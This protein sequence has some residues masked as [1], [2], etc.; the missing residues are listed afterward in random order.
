MRIGLDSNNLKAFFQIELGVI[1]TVHANIKNKI[2]LKHLLIPTQ[3]QRPA[4][5]QKRSCAERER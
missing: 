1:T 2:T 3:L 5:F 4:D